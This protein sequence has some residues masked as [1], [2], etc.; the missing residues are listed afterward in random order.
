MQQSIYE[1]MYFSGRAYRIYTRLKALSFTSNYFDW[2]ILLQELQLKQREHK[3]VAE[4]NVQKDVIEFSLD[5]LFHT[6][7]DSNATFS[8]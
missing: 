2:S 7:D 1:P 3:R 5:S 8:D 4:G 6:E